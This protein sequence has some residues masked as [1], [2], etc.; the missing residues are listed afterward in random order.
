MTA[1][2]GLAPD[3]ATENTRPAARAAWLRRGGVIMIAGPDGSG[4]TTL[5]HALADTVFSGLPVLQIHH[6]RGIGALPGRQPR[7]PTTEPHRHAPYPLVVSWGKALYVFA[8]FLYGWLATIRPFVRAGG[9]VILQRDWWDLLVDPR[10]YRMQPM[11]RLGRLLGRLLPEPDLT[12]VL[13]AEP[14]T[15]LAR[16]AELPSEELAR[17]RAAWRVVRPPGQASLYVDASRPAHDVLE[18][19]ASGL[20]RRMADQSG[21]RHARGW[22]AVPRAGDARWLLPRESRCVA[23][24]S[25]DVYQPVTVKGRIGWEVARGASSLGFMQLA[26]RRGGPSSALLDVIDPYLPV[27]GSFAVARTRRRGRTVVLILGADG[28]PVA[29]AKIAEDA[30]GRAALDREARNLVLLGGLVPS[31]LSAPRLLGRSDGALVVEAVKWQARWRPWHM[32]AEVAHALGVFF[33]GARRPTVG[34]HAEPSGLSHGDVAPWNLLKSGER[35]VLIDWEDA[36]VAG[37]PFHDL[38]HFLAQSCTLLGRPTPR[39]LVEGVRE[40]T[41]WIGEAVRAYARGAELPTDDAWR[42]LLAYLRENIDDDDRRR[43]LK[44][45][46]S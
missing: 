15:I 19:A 40:Q 44:K 16:K 36:R 34:G 17:Q 45:L 21:S 33:R 8:D 5:A 43:L 39:D 4:K 7:G 24:A 1:H 23:R 42:S 38:M 2:A 20:A 13:E 18:Q 35:W 29:V 46:I 11:P 12:I 32:P 26:P 41:G 31:P 27:G 10:R 30:D 28:S 25:L 3:Y 6:R 22:L 9:W 14:D 37:A